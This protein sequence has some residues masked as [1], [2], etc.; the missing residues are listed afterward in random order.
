MVPNTNGLLNALTHCWYMAAVTAATC[1]EVTAVPAGSPS[2]SRVIGV[3]MGIE[4]GLT[5]YTEELTAPLFM[6]C[7]YWE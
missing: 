2:A 3:K 1:A 6:S 4:L 5:V 7:Q